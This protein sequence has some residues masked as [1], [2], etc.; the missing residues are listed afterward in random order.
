MTIVTKY[1]NLEITL[2]KFF[3]FPEEAPKYT[4]IFIFNNIPFLHVSLY[5]S[6]VNL[7]KNET[8]TIVTEY[9]NLEITLLNFLIFFLHYIVVLV[10]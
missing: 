4:V 7:L 10:Y 5:N 6:F 2:L 1:H 9:H 3:N 8:I